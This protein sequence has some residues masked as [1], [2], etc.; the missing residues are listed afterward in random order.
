MPNGYKKMIPFLP[1]RWLELAGLRRLFT[2]LF[3]AT[4][5]VGLYAAWNW[6]CT[7]WTDPAQLAAH[8][9]PLR[10]IYGLAALQALL[11]CS[12]FCALI[13]L[14][15]VLDLLCKPTPREPGR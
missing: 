12:G 1:H 13:R 8:S 15:A 5:L 9:A 2:V 3:Y 4:L 14:S 11:A 10:R 6:A 7:F